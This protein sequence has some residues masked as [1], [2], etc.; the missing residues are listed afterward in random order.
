M[1]H[2]GFAPAPPC[3]KP[4]LLTLD[5][6]VAN[7]FI[8]H[9]NAASGQHFLDHPNAKGKTGKVLTL[10]RPVKANA[11]ANKKGL[12]QHHFIAH[13]VPIPVCFAYRVEA[14]SSRA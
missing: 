13:L 11:S 7:R 12:Q 6:S 2:S 3:A 5:G 10:T 4:T 14:S 9:F 8:G 1:G